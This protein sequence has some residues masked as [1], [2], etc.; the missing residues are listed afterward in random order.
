M[1]IIFFS[2]DLDMIDEFQHRHEI[3]SFTP[4]YELD[5]LFQELKGRERYM[6]I[7]DYDT[8]AHDLNKL[9]YAD[10]LP[11][12]CVILER[13]PAI[14]TG[15]MLISR[16]AQAYGNSR[17][18]QV[19]FAQILETINAGQVWSYPELT[20]ALITKEKDKSLSHEALE[21]VESKLT[22]KESEVIYLILDGF[23]NDA[24]ASKLD[25][26]PRTVKAHVSAIFSKLH[27]NDRV[28]LVLL[29]K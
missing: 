12:N 15:K 10:K 24:I 28:S 19:H 6:L 4:C 23:T 1:Q 25:I 22:P 16:G 9:I 5:T 13:V 29:L 20:A 11:K 7:V 27:V 2:T 21:L 8:V 26:T 18:A 17:M 14:A 3:G